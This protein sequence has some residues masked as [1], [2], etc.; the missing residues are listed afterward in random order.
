MRVNIRS[1]VMF[2]LIALV[3]SLVTGE[4]RSLA[5]DDSPAFCKVAATPGNF[6]GA[7]VAVEAFYES[8]GIEHRLLWDPTC[9]DVTLEPVI[10]RTAKGFQ[11]LKE[12]LFHGQGGTRDKIIHAT[13]VGTLVPREG[14]QRAIVLKVDEIRDLSTKDGPNPYFDGLEL[15][16]K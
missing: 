4:G 1:A 2:A 3:A 8:D 10:P 6:I 11:A 16:E 13:F 9:G 5:F 15:H 14:N 7:A 12:A